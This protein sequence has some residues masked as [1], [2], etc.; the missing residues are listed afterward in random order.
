MTEILPVVSAQGFPASEVNR[1]RSAPQ[2]KLPHP[3]E[4]IHRVKQRF[5]FELQVTQSLMLIQLGRSYKVIF[6]YTAKIF[7][8]IGGNTA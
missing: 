1:R 3:L 2:T 4:N 7:L 8:K 5:P 6:F